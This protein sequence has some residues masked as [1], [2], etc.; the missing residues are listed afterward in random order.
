MLYPEF[1]INLYKSIHINDENKQKKFQWVDL[2]E[3]LINNHKHEKDN[4]QNFC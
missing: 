4:I 1:I 3:N 2:F